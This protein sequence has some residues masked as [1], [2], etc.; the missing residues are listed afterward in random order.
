MNTFLKGRV[1]V[2]SNETGWMVG[3]TTRRKSAARL[4]NE[5]TEGDGRGGARRSGN[6]A[7]S[8]SEG[9]QTLELVEAVAR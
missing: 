8:P 2:D 5:D 4:E 6:G 1:P 9:A 3:G 7:S